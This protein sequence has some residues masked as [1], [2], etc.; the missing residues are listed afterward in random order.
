MLG[1]N[2]SVASLEVFFGGTDGGNGT[3][4]YTLYF[5]MYAEG[6]HLVEKQKPKEQV[7]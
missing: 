4:E 3:L 5:N 6:C 7:G 1:M 2:H